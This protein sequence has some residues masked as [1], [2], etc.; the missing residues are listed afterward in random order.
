MDFQKAIYELQIKSNKCKDF[1]FT[2]MLIRIH[3]TQ[4]FGKWKNVMRSE[5]AKQFMYTENEMNG[6]NLRKLSDVI[7]FMNEYTCKQVL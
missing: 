4:L 2:E 3:S 1:T 7:H 6:E 5:F